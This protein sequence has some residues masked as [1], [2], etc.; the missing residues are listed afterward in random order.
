MAI[1]LAYLEHVAFP[2]KRKTGTTAT[3]IQE[4]EPVYIWHLL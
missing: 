3:V 1:H 4:K 2:E